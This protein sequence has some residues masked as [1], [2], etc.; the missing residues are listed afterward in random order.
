[1][2]INHY[3]NK[4]CSLRGLLLYALTLISAAQI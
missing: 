3:N 2:Y 1:M 4:P